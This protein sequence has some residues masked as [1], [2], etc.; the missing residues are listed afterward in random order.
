MRLLDLTSYDQVRAVL[1]VSDE[2]LTDTTLAL[3]I[4]WR[5]LQMDLETV[6]PDLEALYISS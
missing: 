4:Y 3:P 6:H 2:E 1:G 5:K